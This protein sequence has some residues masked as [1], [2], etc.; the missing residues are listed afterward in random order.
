MKLIIKEVLEKQKK[1][2]TYRPSLFINNYWY[3]EDIKI[4]F[5]ETKDIELAFHRD[6]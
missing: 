6:L 2:K 1:K 4:E 3:E 5:L